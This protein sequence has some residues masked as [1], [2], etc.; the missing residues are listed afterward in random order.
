MCVFSSLVLFFS[1]SPCPCSVSRPSAV[2]LSLPAR[3]SRALA[4]P[5]ARRA[6][7]LKTRV[8]NTGNI[9]CR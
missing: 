8:G 4:H 9:L 5:P 3:R 6:L 1:V 7:A 2:H